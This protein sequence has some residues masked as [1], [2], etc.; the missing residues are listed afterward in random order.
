MERSHVK[1]DNG[2]LLL[3]PASHIVACDAGAVELFAC[4]PTALF[5]RP[6]RALFPTLPLQEHVP[7]ENVRYANQFG[8]VVTWRSCLAW[9][10]EGRAMN[11][12][13]LLSRCGFR[14]GAALCIF[15]RRRP[16]PAVRAARRARVARQLAVQP[17]RLAAGAVDSRSRQA[18]AQN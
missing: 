10:P 6:A 11:V 5:G 2:F 7:S 13:V 9:T 16:E 8:G 1:A 18:G 12:D 4:L 17:I 15:L 3:S 14:P